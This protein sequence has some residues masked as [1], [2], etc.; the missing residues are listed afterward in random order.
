[1][2]TVYKY[3][4]LSQNTL[5]FTKNKDWRGIEKNN[6][7]K[8]IYIQYVYIYYLKAITPQLG[9]VFNDFGTSSKL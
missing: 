3:K 8:F 1:M 6:Y 2:L 7:A 9:Y 5:Y 4:F